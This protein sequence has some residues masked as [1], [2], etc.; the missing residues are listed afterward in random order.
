[1]LLISVNYLKIEKE[2][3]L[4]QIFARFNLPRKHP[5][6]TFGNYYEVIFYLGSCK[7]HQ[8]FTDSISQAAAFHAIF[9][10]FYLNLTPPASL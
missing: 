3:L 8:K 5:Y 9:A 1:M 6:H 2:C 4:S 7:N 10:F